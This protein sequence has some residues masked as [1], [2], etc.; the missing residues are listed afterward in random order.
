MRTYPLRALAKGGSSYCVFDLNDGPGR[1]DD[2]HFILMG[3]PNSPILRY[4]SISRGSDIPGV[5]SGDIVSVKGDDYLVIYHRGLVAKNLVTKK[6]FYL[7]EADF[8]VKSEAEYMGTIVPNRHK[9]HLYRTEVNGE[10]IDFYIDHLY[11]LDPKSKCILHNRRGYGFLTYDSI[12]QY[13]GIRHPQTNEPLF[14]GDYDLH[15]ESGSL[16]ATVNGEKINITKG[17]KL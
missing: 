3:R 5:F 17:G 4:D 9:K 15:M 2:E 11:G 16:V 8:R 14:F 7:D 6:I 1:W 12:S 13:V 10:K